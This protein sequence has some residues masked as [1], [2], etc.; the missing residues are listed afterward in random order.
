MSS[1]TAAA[2]AAASELLAALLAPDVLEICIEDS[3]AVCQRGLG[4]RRRVPFE[5][6]CVSGNYV[7]W[8]NEENHY[9][10]S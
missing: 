4:R 3:L 2:A 1:L 8:G 7:C 5:A 9:N 6:G 10:Q